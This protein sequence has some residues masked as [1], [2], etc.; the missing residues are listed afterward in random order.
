MLLSALYVRFR[1]MQPIWEVTAQILVLLLA[2]H[3][4]RQPSSGCEDFKHI[5]LLNPIAMLLTQMG[6]AFIDP[7][8]LPSAKEVAGGPLIPIIALATIPAMFALG[9]W[10]FTREAPRVAENL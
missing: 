5:A 8:Q 2:D 6:H 7:A 3:V 10:V 9:W 1:D 4:H